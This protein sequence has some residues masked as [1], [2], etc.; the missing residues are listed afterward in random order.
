MP[1]PRFDSVVVCHAPHV[2]REP[3]LEGS[4]LAR[5]PLLLLVEASAPEPLQ[6][7]PG[8]WARRL[9]FR[10]EGCRQASSAKQPGTPC[11]SDSPGPPGPHYEASSGPHRS[12]TAAHAKQGRPLEANGT[13]APWGPYSVADFP[14][15][16]FAA[17]AFNALRSRSF[18][19]PSTWE[20]SCLHSAHLR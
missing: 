2:A 13:E 15:L 1:A 17:C 5:R 4:L 16:Y 18:A 10:R 20:T 8:R 12:N 9:A 3:L 19:A 14:A 6:A 11:A 7:P